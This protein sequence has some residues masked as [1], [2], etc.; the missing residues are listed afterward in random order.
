MMLSL[1]LQGSWRAC[2]SLVVGGAPAEEELMGALQLA[3]QQP[4]R[5][6]FTLL[7]RAAVEST[8]HDLGNPKA[9]RPKDLP[10]FYEV[11]ETAK[12]LLDAGED[13]PCELMA[14]VLKFQMLQVK[15]SDEHRRAGRQVRQTRRTYLP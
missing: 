6:L 2:V 15:A 14:F 11:M 5:R 3:V 10:M 12:L 8:I 4:Q 1:C 13:V 9:K 7:S